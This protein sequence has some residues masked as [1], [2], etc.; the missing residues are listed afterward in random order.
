MDAAG[1]ERHV[2][3][4]YRDTARQDTESENL[5]GDLILCAH[6]SL[7]E[8]ASHLGA[9][10]DRPVR[11][12]KLTGE[13][14]VHD[15]IRSLTLLA[16]TDQIS[17]ETVRR[18]ILWGSLQGVP[19]G[20]LVASDPDRARFLVA[21]TELAHLR[22]STASDGIIDPAA[23]R[24]GDRLDQVPYRP[25]RVASALAASWRVL[26]I[27]CHSDPG[28]MNLGSHVL[29]GAAKQEEIAGHALPG[30]CDPAL[31]HC[32][33]V[34]RRAGPPEPGRV[35]VPV[36]TVRAQVLALM[37][38]KTLD[39]PAAAYP[40]SISLTFGALDGYAAAVIAVLG[41]LDVG[42]DASG[43]MSGL[44]ASGT[45]VGDAV[46]A[47]NQS[48]D[49][50]ERNYGVALMG[51]PALWMPLARPASPQGS[52][53]SERPPDARPVSVALTTNE[54]VPGLPAAESKTA[55]VVAG[56]RAVAVIEPQGDQNGAP[57]LR[58][59]QADAA[60]A[61]ALFKDATR[62]AG[63]AR[64]LHRSLTWVRD[65]AVHAADGLGEA[66]A[67]LGQC[68]DRAE[69]AALDGVRHMNAVLAE[70]HWRDPVHAAAELASARHS[71]DHA[72]VAAAVRISGSDLYGALHEFYELAARADAGTCARCGVAVREAV[73]EDPEYPA[74]RRAHE[75]WLCGS[76][77]DRPADGAALALT[78]PALC[79]PG[80][81]LP[82]RVGLDRCGDRDSTGML[83]VVLNDEPTHKLLAVQEQ[84]VKEA[85]LASL[86]ITLNVPATARSDFHVLWAI[87]V[88]DLT[89]T[90]ASTRVAIAPATADTQAPPMKAG[91][92]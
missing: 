70:R 31:D 10:L 30:G 80:D 72:F 39:L 84:N 8:A 1:L 25:T 41:P 67:E 56:P 7:L 32:R 23:G 27:S 33:R 42:F 44:L 86:T 52:S 4:W 29:C 55:I 60:A 22:P 75:C 47:L 63:V 3:A 6:D 21:K 12:H 36:H 24:C 37:G 78:A 68:V 53:A 34:P 5:E 51:D 64:R 58:D 40:S 59:Y 14:G 91:E 61:A 81:Q 49:I 26:S 28:H 65:N 38:C 15:E 89:V 87:W 46:L 69:A 76:S 74:A 71:W 43:A 45:R 18:W 83:A 35:P 92:H 88:R 73:Y 16:R 54:P 48:L 77:K 85:E 17:T 2:L 57:T 9:A 19:V 13:A 90:F 82:V 66:I 11:L 50:E 20:F 62:R 79:A